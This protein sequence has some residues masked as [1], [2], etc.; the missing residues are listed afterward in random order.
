MNSPNVTLNSAGIEF[1][2]LG[3]LLA[4]DLVNTEIAARRKRYDLLQT[5]QD[6]V[7]WFTTMIAL[8]PD[9][10]QVAI[11]AALSPLPEVLEGLKLLRAILH[12]LFEEIVAGSASDTAKIAVINAHL[13]AGAVTIQPTEAGSFRAVYQPSVPEEA[14]ALACAVSAMRL[15]TER[16][17]SRLH[18][19]RNPHCV[20][21]FYDVT[22]S[23]TREWCSIECMDRA[24]SAE[25]YQQLKASKL[26]E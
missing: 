1:V 24:R 20:L 15:L 2:P 22:R 5:P 12:G 3:E 11:D 14:I 8:R 4:V 9:E 21:F 7:D 17:L 23:A 18:K 19:C 13:G 6:A 26:G 16:D 10:Q 25:R